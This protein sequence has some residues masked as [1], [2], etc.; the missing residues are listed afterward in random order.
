MTE[1]ERALAKETFLAVVELD[2]PARRH[3]LDRAC[4]G[5]DAVRHRVEALLRAKTAIGSSL[6]SPA[7]AISDCEIDGYELLEVLGEGGFGT[8]YRARRTGPVQKEYALKILRTGLASAEA[9]AR[10]R[11]EQQALEAMDHPSIARVLDAGVTRPPESRPYLVMEL[12]N[13]EPITAF[14]DRCRLSIADRVRLI[15]DTCRA[16]QHAHQKGVIHRDLKPANILAGRADDRTGTGRIWIKVI[17]FG[18]AKPA[19]PAP[20]SAHLTRSMQLIG[21]P[22][23]MSPEQ[24]RAAGGL[25]DVDSR[26]DVYAL[27]AVLYELL[28]GSPVV[29]AAALASAGPAQIERL[30]CEAEP[31]PPSARAAHDTALPALAQARSTDAPRLTRSLRRELDWITM[32][33]L[34]PERA[35][36]YQTAEALAA[37][38]ERALAG[39]PVEAAPPSRLYRLSRIIRRNRAGFIAASIAAAVLIAGSIVSLYQMYRAREAERLAVREHLIASTA[40]EFLRDTILAATAELPDGPPDTAPPGGRDVKMRDVLDQASRRIAVASR[41]G[42]RFDGQPGISAAVHDMLARI[43]LALGALP[44]ARRH[45]DDSLDLWTQDRGRRAQ[46]SVRAMILLGLVDRELG[47]GAEAEPVLI[48]AA[49]ISL[50]TCGPDDPLTLHAQSALA[51]LYY[52]GLPNQPEAERLYRAVLAKRTALLGPDHPDTLTSAYGLA[53]TLLAQYRLD[54]AESLHASVLAARRRVLGDNHPDTLWS[55]FNVARILAA[56]GKLQEAAAM[57]LEVLEA[58]R[59]MLGESHLATLASMQDYAAALLALGHPAEAEPIIR[60]GVELGLPLLGPEH[61][62][63]LVALST[64]GATLHSLGR[65]SEALPLVQ[66]AYTGLLRKYGPDHSDTKGA[67]HRLDEIRSS[68][69]Q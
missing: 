27:G 11:V 28:C 7:P 3:Y 65:D 24:I 62:D 59:R 19:R 44:Q 39:E 14:S 18:I 63:Y 47:R 40:N 31:R 21:T 17:D 22:T 64:L 8:V 32:R 6:L 4:A 45:A 66:T 13:G 67:R 5:H 23:Y 58:R 46:E 10:F 43:Y 61:I 16:V 12:V 2:E 49:G 25:G 41:P 57:H 34:S 9:V 42:G 30:V 38:L 37:D 53:R 69:H 50:A 51:S 29:D 60:R 52:W 35:R 56:R 26:A 15:I 1:H 48:E 36:R 20:G 33:A 55:R 68:L 54:E